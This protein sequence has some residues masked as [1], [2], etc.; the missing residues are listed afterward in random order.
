MEVALPPGRS[1]W[2]PRSGAARAPQ[3][4][5]QW[6]VATTVGTHSPITADE[7]TL[8]S[9]ATSH[10]YEGRREGR[11]AGNHMLSSSSPEVV[12]RHSSWSSPLSLVPPTWR[13]EEEL[14]TSKLYNHWIPLSPLHGVHSMPGSD[15]VHQTLSPS[16][17]RLTAWSM[18]CV[19]VC[20]S[21]VWSVARSTLGLI[22]LL[23]L[24]KPLGWSCCGT[25]HSQRWRQQK[26][27]V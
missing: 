18:P 16:S 22:G 7:N 12:V 19:C 2:F 3:P 24:Q 17:V 4:S 5:F 6:Q 1:K 11:Q 21:S 9:P 20:V 26:G 23:E 8:P 13:R 27:C 15:V 25:H 14:Q 10:S